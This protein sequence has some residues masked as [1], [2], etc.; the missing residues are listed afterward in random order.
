M[1]VKAVLILFIWLTIHQI[2]IPL[3]VIMLV[4]CG[5]ELARVRSVALIHKSFYTQLISDPESTLFGKLE[6]LLVL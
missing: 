1:P 5:V 4:V 2:A 6:L 3:K